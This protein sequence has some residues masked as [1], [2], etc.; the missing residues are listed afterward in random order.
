MLKEKTIQVIDVEKLKPKS[1]ITFDYTVPGGKGERV[2]T[3]YPY[4]GI[5]SASYEDKIYVTLADTKN[6]IIE[7]DQLLEGI[8]RILGVR[9]NAI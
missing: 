7:L 6:V 5:I 8:V 4:N 9:D 2:E 1:F 3:G